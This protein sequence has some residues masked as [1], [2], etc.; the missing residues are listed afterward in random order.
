M[1]KTLLELRR[2]PSAVAGLAIIGLLVGISMYTVIAIPYHDAIRLWR[3]G[4]QLWLENPRNA[5]PVWMNL[6][7]GVNLPRTQV[8]SSASAP[9]HEEPVGGGARRIT[10][11]LP[12]DFSPGASLKNWQSSST[13]RSRPRRPT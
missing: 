5:R 10:M 6:L 2:Y 7:P 13:Q 3:G 8:V 9:R 4:E 1:S 12:F 11:S